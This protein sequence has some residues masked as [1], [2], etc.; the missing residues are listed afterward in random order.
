MIIVGEMVLILICLDVSFIVRCWVSECKFV[1]VI[2]YV[3]DGVVV[4]VCLFY[5]ELMFIMVLGCLLVMRL[6][7]I[8]CVMKKN[9]LFNVKYCL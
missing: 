7:M 4:I 5:I 2:E 3:D 8:F 1:F 9:V 6:V